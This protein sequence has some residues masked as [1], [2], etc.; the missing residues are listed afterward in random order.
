[1]IELQTRKEALLL[2]SELNRLRLVAEMSNL[3]GM[4]SFS[5]HLPRIGSWRSVLPPLAG[6]VMALG[7]GRSILAGGLLRKILVAAPEFIRLWR[8]V[9]AFWAGF[10]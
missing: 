10:R 5:K 3:R 8:T 7:A 9:S 2:E 1:M 4:A 6:V